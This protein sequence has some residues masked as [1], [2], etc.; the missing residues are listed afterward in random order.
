[1]KDLKP[2][3]GRSI[4]LKNLGLKIHAMTIDEYQDYNDLFN[5][6][7]LTTN[8]F[9]QTITDDKKD[10]RKYV[11]DNVKNF[12]IVCLDEQG[13]AQLIILFEFIFETKDI[14]SNNKE[15]MQ[16]IIKNGLLKFDTIEDIQTIINKLNQISITINK[17]VIV[18]RDN[19]DYI[20]N[21]IL[22]SSGISLPKQDRK[23]VV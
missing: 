11:D 5:V 7:I 10:L 17:E 13:I 1:M 20:R 8:F 22:K 18:Y 4:V 21:M 19:F 15:I 6:L 12:D 9:L 14:T 23:S 2:I 16:D 3:L